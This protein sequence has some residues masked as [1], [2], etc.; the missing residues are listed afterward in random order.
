MTQLPGRQFI[1]LL[2]MKAFSKPNICLVIGKIQKNILLSNTACFEEVLW[3]T[4][5]EDFF[6]RF[7]MGHA[8]LTKLIGLADRIL[9][10][11][12]ARFSIF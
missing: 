4:R 3:I 1:G 10:G 9:K 12:L 6:Y 5:F 2:N 8:I 11:G 7:V